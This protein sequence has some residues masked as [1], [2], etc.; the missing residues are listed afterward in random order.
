MPRGKAE[1]GA[2]L[3][4]V[5]WI[6]PGETTGWALLAVH[7]EALACPDYAVLD[8]L[9]HWDVGQISG[10]EWEQTRWLT[11]AARGWPGA[12]LGSED[13]IL[14]SY[15]AARSL[16][17]PVRLTAAWEYQMW[18]ERRGVWKQQPAEAK[19][20]VSDDRLRAWHMLPDGAGVHARD[21]LRHGLLF[22]KKAK[23]NGQLRGQAWPK[24]F[25]PSSGE[26]II[27]RSV[28]KKRREKAG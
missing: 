24:L 27:A 14:R 25:V 10:P 9:V 11:E 12:A 23:S 1:G 19:V 2:R 7:P 28:Q 6:D 4:E 16:L 20:T 18:A 3:A 8:N 13:F 21:A 5:F 17:S 15:S 26:M 22:L